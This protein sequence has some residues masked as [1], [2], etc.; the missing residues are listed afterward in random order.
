MFGLPGD[1]A[2]IWLGLVVGSAVMMGV[3]AEMPA[4]PPEAE[5]AATAVDDVAQLPHTAT[6]RVRLRAESIKLGPSGLALRGPGG[7]SHADFERGPVTPVPPGSP[8]ESVLRGT[9]PEDVFGSPAA[10]RSSMARARDAEPTYR[11]AGSELLVRQVAYG[12][13]NGVLVGA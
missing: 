10:F 4:A 8:L 5:R 9:P 6:A 11:T 3:V 2:W 1:A 7:T 13:V 12:E